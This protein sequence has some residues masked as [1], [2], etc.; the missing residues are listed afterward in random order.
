MSSSSTVWSRAGGPL[1]PRYGLLDKHSPKNESDPVSLK[2]KPAAQDRFRIRL[3][4]LATGSKAAQNP[5]HCRLCK[6]LNLRGYK[7]RA[8]AA[9]KLKFMGISRDSFVMISAA[10]ASQ[11]GRTEAVYFRPLP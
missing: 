6:C 3:G 5:P 11:T 2:E 1:L 7:I 9:H 8:S 4:Y 10:R